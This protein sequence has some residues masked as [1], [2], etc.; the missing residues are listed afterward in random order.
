LNVAIIEAKVPAFAR[1]LSERH[2]A[3]N[4]KNVLS[5][6]AEMMMEMGEKSPLLLSDY[7]NIK[8]TCRLMLADN[9]EMVTEKETI[10]VARS[11][12]NSKYRV[13]SNS[14]HPIEKVDLDL[15]VKELLNMA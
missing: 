15:L 7:G 1:V 4:W 9:D 12:P 11:L 10:E 8:T 14:K 13:L 2:G 5:R 6:T 3:E